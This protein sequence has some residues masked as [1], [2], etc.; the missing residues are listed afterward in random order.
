MSIAMK[1]RIAIVGAG[2]AGLS[3]ANRLIEAGRTSDGSSPFDLVVVEAS[4][5]AGGRICSAEFHGENV[6]SG[7]TWI[8]GIEGS[9]IYAIAN[10]IGA[11]DRGGK[12]WEFMDGYPSDIPVIAEGGLTVPPSV[13]NPMVSYYRQLLSMVQTHFKN[14]ISLAD[15]VEQTK[16]KEL[17]RGC[18]SLGDY[19]RKGLTKYLEDPDKKNQSQSPFPSTVLA[20]LGQFSVGERNLGR[21]DWDLRSLR[22][23]VF[24]TQAN[25]ERSI[26][27]ADDLDNVDLEANMEYTEF[28]GMHMPIPKGFSSVVNELMNRLPVGSIMYNARVESIEW[29]CEGRSRAVLLKGPDIAADHVILTVSLG[30]LKSCIKGCKKN[31]VDSGKDVAEGLGFGGF[32]P[33]LPSW[34]VD[35]I[36]RLGFGVVDKVHMHFSSAVSD[37]TGIIF[38]F[39]KQQNG[40]GRLG[41][42]PWWMR[43]TYSLL[44]THNNSRIL[45]SWLAGK[46]A[47][48]MESL[49]N[50]EVIHGVLNTLFAFGLNPKKLSDI[51]KDKMPVIDGVLRSQWGTN[52]LFWGSYSYVPLGSSGDDIEQLAEPLPCPEDQCSKPLQ[53]LFA[54]EAT[55]RNYYSTT[56][57]AFLSGV[58]EAN[59][60]L[61]HYN[62]L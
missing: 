28:P 45:A 48:Q 38:L 25:L 53:I 17:T 47:I 57:A 35:A 42:I 13:V 43:K 3:A 20:E 34:K 4:N 9:P 62:L 11:M 61:K 46:E 52:P 7:A 49:S 37:V 41:G 56:H 26:T 59:K 51:N 2:M 32:Q 58:R 16:V 24:C 60:L 30:V 39:G 19:L 1:P 40:V 12:P 36:R 50:Q 18:R 14:D 27:A 29:S 31:D 6:E 33:P 55:D 23:A 22:E 44:P 15:G 21:P 8:H 54:G 5:R 10:Q